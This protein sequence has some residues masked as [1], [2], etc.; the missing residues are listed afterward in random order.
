MDNALLSGS[1]RSDMVP[2]GLTKDGGFYKGSSVATEEEWGELRTF[3]RGQIK[4]IGDSIA[5]GQVDIAPYRYAGKTACSTCSYK[6]VCHFDAQLAGN[7]YRTLSKMN[8]A[9]L[10]SAIYNLESV[11]DE[12]HT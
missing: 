12:A 2:V 8:G 9:A 5:G 7:P 1:G 10:R 11:E 4:R 3:V 6:P